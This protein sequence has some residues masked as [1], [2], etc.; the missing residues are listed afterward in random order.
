MKTLRVG[1]RNF[2]LGL[3]VVLLC[4]SAGNA[5]RGGRGAGGQDQFRFRFIGPAVG[6]RVSA[7]AGIPG[8]TSTYYAGAASGGVWKSIDGG[9]NW[10][11]I[12]D[13]EPVAAIGALAVATTDPNTIWAGTGEAWAIRDADVMGDG[14]YKSTDAGATWSNVG[15]TEVG[16]IGRIIVHPSNPNVVYVCALGRGTGPQQERG[17]YRTN[18][19]GRNWQRVLFVDEDTGCSGLT[20]D[21]HDPNTLFAG[22]W[23]MVMHTYAMYSGGPSSGIYVSHDA[24]TTWTHVVHPGL[25]K[26]PL[27]KIDVAI[28]PTDSKRVYALIQTADQGSVWRSDDGGVN[29]TNGS[30]Q[31]ALIGRAGYYIHIAVNPQNADEVLITNSSFWLSKDG[32]KSFNAQ[33]WGGGDTHDIWIDPTDGNRVIITHDGGMNI[34]TDHGQNQTTRVTLPIGQMYHVAVDNDVPYHIYG[35]MQDDGTMR[36]LSTTQEAGNNVPGQE[37]AGGRGGGRGGGGGGGRGGGGAAVGA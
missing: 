25:P 18:D 4:A 5:Q 11:P 1:Y 34:T 32:G 26:S 8:D 35:N 21:A 15:L 2:L 33:N 29:W 22:M 31:R 37:P 30:W 10:T 14:V 6:N 16:R 36:G 28:A 9:N 3:V 12:F 23:Q 19:G 13:A 7:I 24:G 27:G 20:L 17:V